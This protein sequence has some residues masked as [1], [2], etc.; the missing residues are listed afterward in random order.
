M[1]RQEEFMT[2]GQKKQTDNLFQLLLEIA[3]FK[4]DMISMKKTLL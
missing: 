4:M 2:G 3:F 1:K